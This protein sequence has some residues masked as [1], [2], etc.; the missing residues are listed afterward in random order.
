M[1]TAYIVGGEVVSTSQDAFSAFEKSQWGEKK[2]KELFILV[3][4]L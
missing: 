1:I 4:R 3:L 2:G